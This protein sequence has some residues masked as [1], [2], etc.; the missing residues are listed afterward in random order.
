MG[1]I[2]T[3]LQQPFNTLAELFDR[4]EEI[5]KQN[6]AN[7]IYLYAP[8]MVNYETSYYKSS[9][10]SFPAISVTGRRCFLNCDHCGGKLLESMF[11]AE[12][13]DKLYTL[14]KRLV[15]KGAKGFLLSG[16][17]N[18]QGYVP[19]EQFLPVVA[20]IKREVSIEV[21]VH[22]GLAPSHIADALA[23]S[24]VDAVLLDI[25]GSDATIK[26]VCHLDKCVDSFN[27]L[28]KTLSERSLPVVPHIVVGMHY[29]MMLGERYA[30]ALISKYRPAAVV[31]VA[32]MP[33]EGTKMMHIA[34]PS[35]QDIARVMLAA[36]L[37]MPNI[38]IVLGCARPRGN[39]RVATDALAVR[40]GVNGI[41]YPSESLF[42]IC[43]RRG[44]HLAFS[45]KCCGLIWRDISS[46]INRAE[47]SI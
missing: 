29:G 14:M 35:P 20:K 25:V 31:I 2:D 15:Q 17:C 42:H 13:P 22:C 30:L 45:E 32:L 38:P 41:T 28:L 40:C 5:L 43:T 19:L 24:G 39:H 10:F 33:L 9:P 44:I 46:S 8:G 11:S 21:V 7:N 27:H 36:R 16:G 37:T 4:A 26:E 3:C 6:F 34:P 47:F 1:I 18:S 23:E 12:S